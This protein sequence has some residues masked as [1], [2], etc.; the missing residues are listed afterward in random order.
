MD[1]ARKRAYRMLVYEATTRIRA[2]LCDHADATERRR[3]ED[4]AYIIADTMHNLA[5]FSAVDF[6]GFD[7]DTFWRLASAA[8]LFHENLRYLGDRDRFERDIELD[9]AVR[10]MASRGGTSAL[11][12]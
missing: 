10:A 8:S 3:N 1:D 6:D 12:P 9:S 5:Y 11:D 4:F 2:C 7:E